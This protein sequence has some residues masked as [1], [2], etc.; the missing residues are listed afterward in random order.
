[1]TAI[2]RANLL[3]STQPESAVPGPSEAGLITPTI[4]ASSAGLR[5]MSIVSSLLLKKWPGISTG[6]A[7]RQII[8]FW[9]LPPGSAV[10]EGYRPRPREVAVLRLDRRTPHRLAG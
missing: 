5:F 10:G 4:P 6:P 8:S 1:M 7:C 2:K 3:A 9:Y